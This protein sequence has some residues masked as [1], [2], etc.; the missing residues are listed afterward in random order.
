MTGVNHSV[1][2]TQ[3]MSSIAS[4]FAGTTWGYQAEMLLRNQDRLGAKQLLYEQL[5]LAEMGL[6]STPRGRAL[7][8][9]LLDYPLRARYNR[10]WRPAVGDFYQRALGRAL[11]EIASTTIE[12]GW[13]VWKIYNM[14]FVV[15]TANFTIGFD[16][17]PGWVFQSPL[18]DR[19]QTTLADMLD[20]LLISHHHADHYSPSFVE[21]MT[22]ARKPVI[23]PS[24]T[25]RNAASPPAKTRYTQEPYEYHHLSQGLQIHTYLGA[26]WRV[27]RNAVH[28]VEADGQVIVHP[29]DNENLQTYDRIIQAHPVDLF[30][31][32][33]WADLENSIKRVKPRA[34]VTG[35][36]NEISHPGRLCWPFST[37]L[38]TLERLR[39]SAPLLMKQTQAHVL[40]WGE[41][42]GGG[43]ITEGMNQMSRLAFDSII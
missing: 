16:V 13:R 29:G 20:V 7:S 5:Y 40:S 38:Q 23:L 24:P 25:W 19:Q 35:H 42:I 39:R 33:C 4:E 15:K 26:Q 31:A 30:L 8:L 37:S 21:K 10:H 27:I 34:I 32:N 28:V 9:S 2:L 17:H 11:E 43:R 14:G 41:S 12:T 18:S 6:A 22:A 3:H 36:E 1:S